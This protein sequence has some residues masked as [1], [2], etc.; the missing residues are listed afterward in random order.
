MYSFSFD[1]NLTDLGTVK[2]ALLSIFK[3]F[4]N[5]ALNIL[6]EKPRLWRLS[7]NESSVE[8]YYYLED[9]KGKELITVELSANNSEKE[10]I[11]YGFIKFN[12][13]VLNF[14]DYLL[15]IPGIKSIIVL[16]SYFSRWDNGTSPAGYKFTGGLKVYYSEDFQRKMVDVSDR[17]GKYKWKEG[18]LFRGGSDYWFGNSFFDLIPKEVLLT[19]TDCEVNEVLPNGYVLIRLFDLRDYWEDANQTRL[20]NFRD[21]LGIDK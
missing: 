12:T 15:K 20:A 6:A 18:F 21:F 1:V 5:E 3:I 11:M 4:P 10:N 2:Q 7:V 8:Y 17:P 16:N 9:Y 14:A 13:E 19:F